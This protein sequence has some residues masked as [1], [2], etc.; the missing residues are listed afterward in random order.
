MNALRI[1]ARE[2]GDKSF[3]T[4]EPCVRGHVGDRMVSDGKCHECLKLNWAKVRRRLGR[5]I[6]KPNEQALAAKKEGR[7]K[8]QDG[9]PC[10]KGHTSWR[11]THNKACVECTNAAAKAFGKASGYKYRKAWVARNP[12]ANA[13]YRR[14]RR[15]REA[16]ALNIPYTRLQLSE[17]MSMFG[18]RCAYCGGDFEHID[19]AIPLARGGPHIL[20]NLRPACSTCNLSKNSKTIA[21]WMA[22]RAA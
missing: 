7:N 14:A 20:A 15:A 19:H 16:E 11:W 9:R 10:A 2:R 4:G 8:Y 12:D 5:G 6:F 13:H 17:R 22:Y 1:A 21:E 18:D 3:C